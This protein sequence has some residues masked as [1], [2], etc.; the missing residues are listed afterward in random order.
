MTDQADV[1]NREEL[2]EFPLYSGKSLNKITHFYLQNK[3][4]KP[5]E[6]IAKKLKIYLYSKEDGLSLN[7][8]HLWTPNFLALKSVYIFKERCICC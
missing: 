7:Q 5:L 2:L 6:L 4:T 1:Q 8:K 3:M